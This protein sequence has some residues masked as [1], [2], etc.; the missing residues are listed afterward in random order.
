MTPSFNIQNLLFLILSLVGLIIV[1]AALRS[2]KQA[3]T[4]QAWPGTQGRVIESRVESHTS[5]D[6]DGHHNTD[7]KAIVRYTYS[8]MG[9]EY[10]ANRVAF[11]ARSS[12]R[13]A[14]SEV[15][16]RYPLDQQ[17]TVYYDPD[18]PGQAVLERVSGSGMLQI[19]IG[20][21]LIFAGIYFAFK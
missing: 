1:I 5:T 19:V 6:S 9:Q 10:S 13:N 12:N 8:V 18:K 15:V 11:G 16:N 17:V 2:R 4:S 3:E 20:I 14:A 7:Y 21:L